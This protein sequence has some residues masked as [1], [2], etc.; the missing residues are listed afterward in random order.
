MT[1]SFELIGLPR[2]NA[3]DRRNH[4]VAVKEKTA[5]K[6][7]TL[8]ALMACRDLHA[9][10]AELPLAQAKLRLTRYSAREPDYDGLVASFKYIVDALVD[11]G[12]IADDKPSVIGQPEYRWEHAPPKHGRVRVEVS[13]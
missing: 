7:H 10:R 4:W 5:W 1:I 12:V 13:G 2:T 8:A 9:S 6:Q 3:S 11:G